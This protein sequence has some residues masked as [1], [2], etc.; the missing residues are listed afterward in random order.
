MFAC[1]AILGNEDNMK[2]E[3]KKVIYSTNCSPW[4]CYNIQRC[5]SLDI[6]THLP[7]KVNSL[8]LGSFPLNYTWV[9]KI[10]NAN[11]SLLLE[12]RIKR[13]QFRKRFSIL[14]QIQ[15]D[16]ECGVFDQLSGVIPSSVAV[17]ILNQA[18]PLFS[19]VLHN[20]QGNFANIQPSRTAGLL[21]VCLLLKNTF[22][23]S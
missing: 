2:G 22:Y 4:T 11:Y 23:L 7:V 19:L 8:K 21:A 6:Q 13:D 20:N 3:Q 14:G 9:K 17:Y 15:G 5:S 1:I 12:E 18:M 10:S 16:S